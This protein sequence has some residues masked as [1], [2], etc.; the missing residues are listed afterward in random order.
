MLAVPS[1]FMNM[2]IHTYVIVS[3]SSFCVCLNVKG[4]GR[5]GEGR[6][7]E[8]LTACGTYSETW[9]YPTLAYPRPLFVQQCSVIASIK[10]C[11][12]HTNFIPH[13]VHPTPGSS[14]TW[15]MWHLFFRHNIPELSDISQISLCGR[16]QA[17]LRAYVGTWHCRC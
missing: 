11:T 17:D 6:G 3:C 7:K 4:W 14:N 13:L 8:G 10:L 1:K 9:F 2:Y 5:E 15:F 16:Y 12:V